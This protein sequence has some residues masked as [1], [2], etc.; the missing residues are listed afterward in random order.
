VKTL[1]LFEGSLRRTLLEFRRYIFDTVSGLVM[2]YGFFL[3]LFFGA[4]VFGGGRQGFGDTLAAVIVSFAVWT[5]TVM[6]LGT[7]TFELTQEAQ[8]GTLEQLSMSPFG[9]VQVL[10]ARIVTMLTIYFGMMVVLLVLMMATTGR[11]L[12]LAPLSTLPLIALT[13]IG[14]IGLGFMLAGVAI[15]FKR[16][17]QAL[18]VWQIAVFGL[19]A[20]P[21][22]RV[23]FTKYLPLAWGT[24]LLRRVMVDGASITS[25]PIGDTLFLAGNSVA[26]FVLG[27]V[28][29]R[30]FE[31]VAR[32]RGLLGHY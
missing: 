26:Y 17:Q 6:A 24:T 5:L 15:V 2:I 25:M 14:V 1:V 12:N 20:A 7:L 16:V 4:K 32:E 8:L 30:R 3:L 19:I 9:L 23:P 22:T 21:V 27:I 29:F 11:W 18:Q 31:R 13:T 10:V 28:V